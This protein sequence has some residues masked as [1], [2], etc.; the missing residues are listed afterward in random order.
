MLLKTTLVALVF[1]LAPNQ[2]IHEGGWSDGAAIAWQCQKGA[3]GKIK[4][5]FKNV[6]GKIYA[7]ELSCGTGV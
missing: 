1:T 4:F 3:E 5:L 2:N 6:D 7:G